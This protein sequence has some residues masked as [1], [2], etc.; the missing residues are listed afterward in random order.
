VPDARPDAAEVRSFLPGAG[1]A[2]HAV[3]PV[4]GGQ[5]SWT[6]FADGRWVVQ[7]PRSTAPHG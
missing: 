5:V 2:A 6:Y 1:L 7:I 3:E 4:G